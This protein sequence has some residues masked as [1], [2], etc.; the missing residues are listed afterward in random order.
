MSRPEAKETYYDA[1]RD[2]KE[3]THISTGHLVQQHDEM[4]EGGVGGW[5]GGE[6]SSHSLWESKKQHGNQNWFDNSPSI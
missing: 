1:K 5:L 3:T 4:V 2:P 6:G